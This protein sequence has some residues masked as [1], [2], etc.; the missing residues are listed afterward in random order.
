MENRRILITI[1]LVVILA[2]LSVLVF[3]RS[4][5]ILYLLTGLSEK[6]SISLRWKEWEQ[7]FLW[8]LRPKH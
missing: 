2:F 7:I 5:I 3:S 1:T 8:L 4:G 6:D